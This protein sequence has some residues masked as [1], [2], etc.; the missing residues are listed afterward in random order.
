MVPPK[1]CFL[2]FYHICLLDF[3]SSAPSPR[4]VSALSRDA[5]ARL[6]RRA[7]KQAT[8]C[9]PVCARLGREWMVETCRGRGYFHQR[10]ALIWADQSRSNGDQSSSNRGLVMCLS[11][12]ALV[13][14]IIVV[15]SDISVITTCAC[16]GVRLS[17]GAVI[18]CTLGYAII[19]SSTS[20]LWT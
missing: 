19:M 3:C 15:V 12:R 7:F 10:T 4:T 2:P 1:I 13:I 11:Q 16:A 20:G 18:L 9:S 8:K 17:R 6:W 14:I 5:S